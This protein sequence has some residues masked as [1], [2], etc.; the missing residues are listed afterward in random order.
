LLLETMQGDA[1]LFARRDEIET[2]WAWL[3]PL[4]EAWKRDEVPLHLHP[5]GTW[6]PETADELIERDGRKW[7]RP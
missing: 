4:L 6:G 1:T 5:A 3:D 7:R 2:A